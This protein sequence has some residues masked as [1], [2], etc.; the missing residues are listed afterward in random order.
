MPGVR[1][2]FITLPDQLLTGVIKAKHT[3]D[4][5]SSGYLQRA[6]DHFLREGYWKKHIENIRRAYYEK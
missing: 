1:I 5:A 4:I 3:T 6:F 2:G